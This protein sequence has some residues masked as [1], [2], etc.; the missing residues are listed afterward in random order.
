MTWRFRSL[1]AVHPRACG[2]RGCSLGLFQRGDGSSPRLRGTPPGHRR[3][4]AGCRFIPAPAGNAMASCCRRGSATVHPRACG[5]RIP[6]SFITRPVAGSSPRLRG[7]RAGHQARGACDRFI[8]APAGNAMPCGHQPRRSAVHPRACGERSTKCPC[9]A[10]NSGSS[11]RLRGTPAS[12]CFSRPAERFIPAPAG[13]ASPSRRPTAWTAVHPRACGERLSS[14]STASAYG[15]SS[16]RLRGTPTQHKPNTRKTRFIPA[17]A[18]NA[19][20][21]ARSDPISPVHPRAC[22]ERRVS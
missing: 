2:E 3:R 8:P 22:G 9:S 10:R 20:P 19:R 13:N 16:P 7:T 17:P 5:E 18:G 11:P 14:S 1:S 12:T 4:C 15:G 6:S 21:S